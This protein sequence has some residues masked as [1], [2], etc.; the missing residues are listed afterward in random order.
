M[1]WLNQ[2]FP[3]AKSDTTRPIFYQLDNE[4]DLWHGT[5]E[6]VR[7]RV[8]G[9]PNLLTYDEL[10]KRTIE[11]SAAIKDVVP[12]AHTFGAGFGTWSGAMNLGRW[13][14]PDPVAGTADFLDYFLGKMREAEQAQ[15]R[16]LLDVLDVHWYPEARGDGR[17]MTEDHAASTPGEIQARIQAP[18]SLWDPTYDER[19]W[20]SEVVG[21]PIRLLPR[22]R[23]KVAARYPG[24]KLAI[25]EYFYGGGTDISGG[26]AQADVLGI[27]GREG[28]FAAALWPHANLSVYGGDPNRAYG[29]IF[30]GFQMF[31]DYDGRG[32]AFGDMS[33]TA[34]NSDAVK[35][36]VYASADSRNPGRVVIVTIN[37]TGSPLRAAIT[38]SHARVL[39][40]A[41]VYTL[42]SASREP[43]RQADLT[44]PRRNALVYTLPPMSVS[45]LVLRE[46]GS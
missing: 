20:V 24:T 21:G 36:S 26:I 11:Y 46:S 39:R 31:R 40:S 28:L 33:V 27:F 38:V 9:R 10:V 25:A 23:E 43:Q 30:G 34:A 1:W 29:Y 16:R 22:L 3:E 15:G 45:T 42:T 37:K 44:L 13:P 6:Q 35:S 17:R 4:P 41:E 2:T 32:G 8:G 5:H 18:R 14:T 19:S 7:S 12:G